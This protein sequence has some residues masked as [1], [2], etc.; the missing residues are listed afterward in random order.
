MTRQELYDLVWSK[1][2][3][4]IAKDFGMSDHG[5]LEHCVKNDIPTPSLGYWAKI[6][7][8]SEM[9]SGME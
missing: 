4:H 3:T 9:L 2:M 5:I 6:A 1:P 8:G 7:R